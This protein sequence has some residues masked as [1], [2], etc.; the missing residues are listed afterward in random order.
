MAFLAQTAAVRCWFT[1]HLNVHLV[2]CYQKSWHDKEQTL[3]YLVLFTG[4]AT[5]S[6]VEQLNIACLITGAGRP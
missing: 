4:I 3:F 2:S 1:Q 6:V 5:R